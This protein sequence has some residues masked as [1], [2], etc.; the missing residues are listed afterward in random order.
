MLNQYRLPLFHACIELFPLYA[1]LEKCH[2]SVGQYL[3]FENRI[4][5]E[6]RVQPVTECKWATNKNQRFKAARTSFP[7]VP[8]KVSNH[9]NLAWAM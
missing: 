7:S 3:Q 6:K 5:H 8:E 4:V 9:V 2:V 1:T